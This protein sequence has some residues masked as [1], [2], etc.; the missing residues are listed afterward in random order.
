MSK[1]TSAGGIFLKILTP[2]WFEFI[3][4]VGV[5]LATAGFLVTRVI[6]HDEIAGT[7]VERTSSDIKTSVITAGQALPDSYYQAA[8][9]LNGSSIIG[10]ATILCFWALIG[11]LAY[12]IVNTL[13]RGIASE[14][15]LFE[16]ISFL[17][18]N[19]QS[20]IEDSIMSLCIR[21]GAV[22]GLIGFA[23]MF[24][25]YLLPQILA[26]LYDVFLPDK[27]LATLYAVGG[28][29]LLMVCLH[30]F[31]VLM[32][33]MLLQTRVFFTRYTIAD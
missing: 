31:V 10:D 29:F 13:W 19:R 20:A 21:L 23:A 2:S 24:R 14:I 9:W 4:L 8:H 7:Y 15:K 18:V 11:L 12:A 17:R 25:Y 32:R 30:I 5:A 6:T 33:L 1:H 28:I 16:H 3:G 26:L 27:Y 22:L